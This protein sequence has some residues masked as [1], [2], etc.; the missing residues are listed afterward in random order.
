MTVSV[1]RLH[2]KVRLVQLHIRD[3]TVMGYDAPISVST[4]H[5]YD[6]TK[7]LHYPSSGQSST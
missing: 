2:N 4:K 7:L 1:H 5:L 6:E 3:G